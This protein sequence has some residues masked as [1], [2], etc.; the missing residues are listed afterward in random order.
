V[1]FASNLVGSARKAM[2]LNKNPQRAAGF[3]VLKA[4]DVPSALLE[5][6]YMTS[7]EDLNL[8]QSQPW[9]DKAAGA[10]A[11]AI[12]EFFGRPPAAEGGRSSFN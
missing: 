4:P 3:L 5:L 1:R 11:E 6:G 9:R 8:M 7:K 10:L 12:D 2:R